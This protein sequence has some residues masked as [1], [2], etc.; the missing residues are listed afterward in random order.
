MSAYFD[1]NGTAM[2][3]I[4]DKF[5]RDAKTKKEADHKINKACQNIEN[6]FKENLQ[7]LTEENPEIFDPISFDTFYFPG[8][9][10]HVFQNHAHGPA[11]GIDDPKQAHAFCP[12][13]I[14]I[15]NTATLT[16]NG[17]IETDD[18]DEHLQLIINAFDRTFNADN[19]YYN[20]DYSLFR[21]NLITMWEGQQDAT[22]FNSDHNIVTIPLT[23]G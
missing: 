5:I 22:I 3:Y 23:K 10:I 20:T 7:A 14:L 11:T 8:L 16:I 18:Y 15:H 1:I 21:L 2:V 9:D 12:D 17:T 4:N 6:T 13:Q 19:H